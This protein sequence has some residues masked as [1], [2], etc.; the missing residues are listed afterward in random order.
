MS[1]N[2]LFGVIGI[3]RFGLSLA[4]G[5]LE[6]GK[7]VIAIDKDQAS[8]EPLRNQVNDLMVMER[9]TIEE[10]KSAGI[11]NCA[12]VIVCI[13]K[14][15]EANLLATMNAIELGVPRV[16][17]KA[18]N[19]EHGRLLRR[20]GAEIVNPEV[21][22]GAKLAKTLTAKLT[23]DVLPIGEDFSIIELVMND[24]YADK[25]VREVNFR[26]KFHINIVAIVRDDKAN[27]YIAPSTML[28][29]GDILVVSGDNNA[30]NAFEAMN[31]KNL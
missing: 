22:M 7:T 3:G 9:L 12:T 23:L 27:G 5:L 28:K 21:E 30:V 24:K 26:E 18:L 20:I 25:T 29:A 15:I 6:E 2:N 31:S 4:R 11:E 19:E 17:A 16:I 1:D 10:L 13:G 8:L 14:N